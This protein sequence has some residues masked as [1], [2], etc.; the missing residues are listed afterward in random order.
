MGGP[1]LLHLQ[2]EVRRRWPAWLAVVLVIGTVGGLAFGTLAGARRT[3]TAFDRM[4]EETVAAD[5][6]VNPNEGAFSDLDP[7]EVAQLPGVVRTG[8]M[9]GGGGIV[10]GAD[11]ELDGAPQ[12]FV[13]RDPGVMVDFDRPRVVDGQLFDPADPSGVMVTDDVADRHDLGV[14]DTLT[15][16]TLTMAELEAWE[17]SGDPEPSLTLHEQRVDAV[18][19]PSDGVVVDEV[20]QYGQVVLPHSFGVE[21]EPASYY[22]GILVD[23]EGDDAAV[24][25]FLEAVRMLEPE[26]RFEIKTAAATRDTVERGVRPHVIA[27]S[28]FAVLIGFAGTVVCGQAVARQL[29]PLVSESPALRAVGMGRGD[30]RRA[31]VL[32]SC[33]LAIPG[34]ALAVAVAVAISPIFPV[35]VARRAEVEPGLSVDLVVLVPGVVALVSTLLVWPMV[36]ARR[37]RRPRPTSVRAPAALERLARATDRPVVA[38]ALRA[39]LSSAAGRSEAAPRGALAGMAVAVGAV[40]ATVTFGAGLQH[41]VDRPEAYGWTWDAMVAP[42][43]DDDYGP[44]LRERIQSTP[45]F[46]ASTELTVDQLRI[47]PARVPAVGMSTGDDGPA[48]TV[49]AGRLPAGA[50]EI[51]LGGRTMDRLGV[52]VGDRIEVGEGDRTRVLEVVGQAV[53]PGLG[54]FS[55]ADR[56]ELGKGALLDRATLA[57]VGEG[58]EASFIGIGAASRADLEAGIARVT[59]GFEAALEE[60]E[61]EVL[62]QPQRPSDVRSLESVRRTPELIAAVLAALAGVA[63]SFVLVAGI[64]GRRRELM[65]LRTFG[66]RGRDLGWTVVCQSTVT[67]LLALAIGIPLGIVVGRTSW[68][69]LAT[70]IGVAPEPRVPLS[71]VAVAAG[72]LLLGVVFAL[73]PA[74]I[75]ARVRP[76]TALRPQ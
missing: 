33:A 25:P 19:V 28:A 30:L 44:A 9:D 54:T 48:P 51:A 43:G 32:R 66:F 12:V 72:V 29:V 21:H 26:E 4:A 61:L 53:L 59:E 20:Y 1:L 2:A 37:L 8:I 69:V 50:D 74:A 10:V 11:G 38:T 70:S 23:L 58:F 45:E 39:A 73:V 56:T 34:A 18:I 17:D 41:L 60:G 31:V 65:L 36:A 47:G 24:L 22:Y 55:G 62:D 7:A 49:A 6:L 76:A 67:A 40:A 27:L 46:D 57:E 42:P 5:V 15:I 13:Q 63:S 3:A 14:G 75:A 35:G 52:G 64:R 16:G 68:S 71:L